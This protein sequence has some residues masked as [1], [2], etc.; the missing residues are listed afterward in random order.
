MSAANREKLDALQRKM[1]RRIVGYRSW[2]ADDGW[3]EAGRDMKRRLNR[4][5][6]LY[7]IK[8]WTEQLQARKKTLRARLEK[9]TGPH[10]TRQ[11]HNWEPLNTVFVNNF[12]FCPRRCPGHPRLRWDDEI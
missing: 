8:P 4:A 5:L 7:P 9:T 10:L 11:V 2:L 3:V 12:E 1:L 6:E